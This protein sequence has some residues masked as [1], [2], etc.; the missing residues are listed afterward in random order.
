MAGISG[1][2]AQSF[3]GFAHTPRPA[4]RKF[5]VVAGIET[6]LSNIN[7]RTTRACV[8]AAS[9]TSDHC[10]FSN[11][12]SAGPESTSPV[13]LKREPW[14]GQ[15]QVRSAAFQCTMHFRWVQTGEHKV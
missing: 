12:S 13:G 11:G 3:V 8:Y 9:S 1:W 2:R 10:T 4:A 15:S 7:G 14:Q 5:K 6:L